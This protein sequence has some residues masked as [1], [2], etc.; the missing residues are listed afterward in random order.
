MH[1][2]T[3]N[4]VRWVFGLDWQHLP[5]IDG[6]TPE[7]EA[8]DQLR[9]SGATHAALTLIG[10]RHL[11]GVAKGP[12]L[13][14]R[15][16][17]AVIAASKRPTRA[18]VLAKLDDGQYWMCVAGGHRFD[19][20]SDTVLDAR[21]AAQQ[22][23]NILGQ[24]AKSSSEDLPI[25]V[26]D[27][28]QDL[29]TA[30]LHGATIVDWVDILG[31]QPPHDAALRNF[32]ARTTREKVIV[33]VLIATAIGGGGFIWWKRE[34]AQRAAIAALELETANQDSALASD[35]TALREAAM[36]AAVRAALSSD[37]ATPQPPVLFSTCVDR[38][39]RLGRY[40]GGWLIKEAVCVPGTL[41]LSVVIAH[42]GEP[43]FGNASSLVRSAQD[44]E[45][46]VV[47]EPS[48]TRNASVTVPLSGAVARVAV[49]T[50]A[51]LPAMQAEQIAWTDVFV[52]AQRGDPQLSVQVD[53]PILRD[54][55][56]D[57]PTDLD[58][59]G[60]PVTKPVD[61]ERAYRVRRIVQTAPFPNRLRLDLS[62]SPHVALTRVAFVPTAEALTT[63][64]ELKVFTQ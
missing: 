60:R 51:D 58:P 47:F 2:S 18:F 14:R 1:S 56:F 25:L 17:A 41:T 62:G 57:D 10:D 15:A 21:R 12:K 27:G 7:A 36:D 22:V 3:I 50:P 54:I 64:A 43:T 52:A 61:A 44:I 9:G 29:N 37:T 19:P 13:P 32:G 16:F 31:P 20:R 55:T 45:G 34:Q 35:K 53:A 40:V 11:V 5:N 26:V 39:Q 8:R 49:D 24:L 6:V 46:S 48:N 38:V 42:P 28:A 30:W 63:T 33:G 4:D 23:D 59:N